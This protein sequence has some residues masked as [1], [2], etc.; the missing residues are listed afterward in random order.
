MFLA[1]FGVAFSGA[2]APG[3]LMVI[4]M[5]HGVRSGHWAGVAISIGH[6]VIELAMLVVLVFALEQVSVLQ[7]AGIKSFIF[8]LGALVLVWMAWGSFR[9]SRSGSAGWTSA[10]AT[11]SVDALGVSSAPAYPASIPW[12]P[13]IGAGA[14]ATL[15]NPYWILWWLTIGAGMVAGIQVQGQ[16]LPGLGA[17]FA[18]HISA[19]IFCF[20]LFA[21]AASTGQR[22]FGQRF[23]RGL[24]LVLSICLVL[25][26][27]SF[28]YLAFFPN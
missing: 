20:V 21:V 7:N 8:I 1:A 18:G 6:A 15:T 11:A 24:M 5:R 17:F 23:Y 3:P 26:A 22:L 25:F 13:I 9:E 27:L 10:P 4:T 16:G 12:L 19:D 14:A 28:I 2:M